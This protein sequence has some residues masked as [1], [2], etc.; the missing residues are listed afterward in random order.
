MPAPKHPKKS[1]DTSLSI[2]PGCCPYSSIHLLGYPCR[3]CPAGSCTVSW[4][5]PHH[6]NPS[7]STSHAPGS[8]SRFSA[9]PTDPK[10]AANSPSVDGDNRRSLSDL[11]ACTSG[12]SPEH[13]CPAPPRERA[14]VCAGSKCVCRHLFSLEV[15]RRFPK[16]FHHC[17]TRALS[18]LAADRLAL[19]TPVGSGDIFEFYGAF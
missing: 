12:S 3:H 4:R 7:P 11:L 6:Q 13:C 17:I 5:S 18:A 16:S 8:R 15:H 19:C 9:V 10:V 2:P 14:G 1:G